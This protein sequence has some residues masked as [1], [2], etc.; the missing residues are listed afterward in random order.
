MRRSRTLIFCSVDSFLGSRGQP[1]FGFESFSSTLQELSIPCVWLTSRTRA[2]LEEPRRRLGA[3]EPFVAEGGC[4]IYLPEDYFHVKTANTIRLGR[5]LCIPTARPEPA[6]AEALEELSQETGV[7]TVPLRSLSRRELATNTGLPER[8]AER[9][10]ARDF[11]ELFY[12]AGAADAEIEHFL[13]LGQERRLVIRPHSNLWSLAVGA[14]V[15]DCVRQL[16]HLYDRAWHARVRRIGIASSTE[17]ESL[18][19][20]F[21][22]TLWITVETSQQGKAAGLLH[23]E[24]PNARRLHSLTSPNL[25]NDVLHELNPHG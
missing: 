22:R 18:Y 19:R 4:G 1:L 13:R 14:S 10:R 21:D 25:W 11:D 3:S 12:F 24:F 5:Y 23:R 7:T 17:P 2:E 16:S 8:E 9:M 15:P 20:S 6:S